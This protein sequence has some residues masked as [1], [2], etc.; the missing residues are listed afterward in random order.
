ML[1]GRM[2][3]VLGVA[4]AAAAWPVNAR[5]QGSPVS[6]SCQ[7]YLAQPDCSEVTGDWPGGSAVTFVASCTELCGQG[8]D[9]HDCGTGEQVSPQVLAMETAAA[10]PVAG[11]FAQLKLCIGMP[12]LSFSGALQGGTSYSVVGAFGDP[13]GR[14]K[15]LTF[16][17]AGAVTG[18][19]GGA[20]P[21]PDSG[22]V[23]PPGADGS[24]APG[25][26]GGG[27]SPPAG[28]GGGSSGDGGSASAGEGCD[29]GV[30]S[31][32]STGAPPLLALALLAWLRRR[33]S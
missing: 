15:L 1:G 4:L 20:R 14:V 10:Q 21:A 11:A 12:L 3:V 18:A 8:A 22:V 24:T 23:T 28:D 33:R 17:T 30:S 27:T 2:R 31:D 7:A 6:L 25:V 32:L 9:M 29:C 13:H 16:T 26:D 5:A 19:D